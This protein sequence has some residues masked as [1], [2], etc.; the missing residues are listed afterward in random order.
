MDLKLKILMLKSAEREVAQREIAQR[1]I[2]QR[3][4]VLSS[5]FTEN[6]EIHDWAENGTIMRRIEIQSDYW[7]PVAVHMQIMSEID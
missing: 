3:G 4:F 2:A 1:E 5:D 6:A 7:I